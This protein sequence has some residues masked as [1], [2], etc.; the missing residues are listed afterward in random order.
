MRHRVYGFKLG[1]NTPHRKAMW[2]NMATSLITHGEITTTIPK[3]K[4]LVPMIEKL[5]TLAKQGD[6]AARRRAISILGQNNIMVGDDRDFSG[7]EASGD[8]VERNKYGEIV[9][10]TGRRVV[11]KLFEDLATATKD[12]VGGYTRII[13]ITKHRIGDAA[14]LCVL[15]L[16]GADDVRIKPGM[17]PRRA[18]ANKRNDYAAKLRKAAPA[19][20]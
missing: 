2:K 1:R 10:T 11:T 19:A 15:Q 3:A 6:L 9:R 12:R 8:T 5:I 17:N 7:T 18:K 4:S 13:R 20:E 14:D 16:V